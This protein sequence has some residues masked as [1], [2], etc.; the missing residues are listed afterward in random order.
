MEQSPSWEGNRFSTSQAITRILWNPKVQYR[1][2]KCLPLVPILSQI[3]SVHTPYQL[4]EG[5]LNIIL[6]S[7]YVSSKLSLSLSFPH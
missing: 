2:Y 4:L 5:H 7:S 3:N 1:S 6:P